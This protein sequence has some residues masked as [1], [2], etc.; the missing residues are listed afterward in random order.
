M[1]ESYRARLLLPIAALLV[2]CAAQTAFAEESGT[3]ELIASEVH[4]YTTLEH[5][6]RTITGGPL[7]GTASIVATS[8]GPFTDGADYRVTCV[9]YVKK[10]DAGLDLE[11]PCTMTDGAG[12][13][14]Y[15]LAERRAGDVAAGGGG[16]GNHRILGG[17]G[18]FS[19]IVGNC[20]YTTSY[21]PGK[22]IV[23]RA[24]CTWRRP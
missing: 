23:T 18:K 14:L 24:K 8:G 12:D 11:A 19:G 20:P 5:A 21:L 6:G 4:D 7:E 22:W 16:R 15:V 10:S 13:A 2:V 9:V 3:Y 17:T 1:N